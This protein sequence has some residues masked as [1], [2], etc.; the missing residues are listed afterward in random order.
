M[1]IYKCHSIESYGKFVC[2][3]AEYSLVSNKHQLFAIK[4]INMKW[5]KIVKLLLNKRHIMLGKTPSTG[6][7]TTLHCQWSNVTPPSTFL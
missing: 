3:F 5:K 6:E 7:K 4:T 1:Y 2:C